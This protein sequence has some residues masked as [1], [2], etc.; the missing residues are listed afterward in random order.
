MTYDEQLETWTDAQELTVISSVPMFEER[1]IIKRFFN[2]IMRRS[3]LVHTGK[4]I[5]S[6]NGKDWKWDIGKVRSTGEYV[7][8]LREND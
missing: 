3:N 8:E 6:K 7:I 5:V 2:W 4:V 1:N